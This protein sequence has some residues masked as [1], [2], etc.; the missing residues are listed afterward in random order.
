MTYLL[1]DVDDTILDWFQGFRV[2]VKHQYDI[3]VPNDAAWDLTKRLGLPMHQVADL[4][5]EFNAGR[6]E[7]GILPP[8]CDAE[9]TLPKFHKAGY[10][11]IAITS[12]GTSEITKA[13]RRANMF[14]AFGDIF[15][16]IHFLDYHDD[17]GE[18]LKRYGTDAIWVEDKYQNAK[19]GVE[20]RI[21]SFVVRRDHNVA[22]EHDD[23]SLGW[24]NSWTELSN[25]FL[26]KKNEEGSSVAS[27][28]TRSVDKEMPKDDSR[29]VKTL[30][31]TPQ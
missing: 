28:S 10:E 7:F 4:V 27:N 3:G 31:I 5:S 18:Y 23:D 19:L 12:C 21:P 17:K 11:L 25:K 22:F 24:I 26:G 9:I 2:F 1:L 14:H 30:S 8:I 13:L 6:W 15:Q 16:E 20:L 29:V